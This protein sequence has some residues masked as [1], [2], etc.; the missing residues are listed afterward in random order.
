MNMLAKKFRLPIQTVLRKK[1]L[2]ARKDEY[3]NVKIFANQLAFSRFG[4]VISRKIDKR[5]VYRN[6]LKRLI[7]NLIR[8]EK[9]YLRPGYDVL[10]YVS[11]KII[12]LN[13]IEV[14]NILKNQLHNLPINQC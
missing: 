2:F 8:L 6:R 13:K 12:K 4:A 7:F 14:Q 9:I 3:F 1:P 5:A 11:P 10:I